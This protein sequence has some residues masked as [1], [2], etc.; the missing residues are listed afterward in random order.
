M[1]QTLN[2]LVLGLQTL[3]ATDSFF[4]A[5]EIDASEPD[6]LVAVVGV[7]PLMNHHCTVQSG[8]PPE[9]TR[10]GGA[11]N[12][13]EMEAELE[14][15]YLAQSQNRVQRR[16]RRETAVAHVVALIA[17]HHDLGIGDPEIYAEIREAERDDEIAVKGTAPAAIVKI[18]IAVQFIALSAA[19]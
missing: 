1:T 13:W 12:T 6:D 10:D 2:A 11:A 9:I 15:V 5:A 18:T 19:G 7:T 3:L 4:P 17:A 14:V 8:K 16:A